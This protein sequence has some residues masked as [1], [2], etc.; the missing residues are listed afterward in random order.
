MSYGDWILCEYPLPDYKGEG[1]QFL[2]KDLDWADNSYTITVDGRLLNHNS[3][4]HS[5]AAED[6]HFHTQ[7]EP[8]GVEVEY[9]G[10][11]FFYDD[12]DQVYQARFRKGRV[13]WINASTYEELRRN[14]EK[15]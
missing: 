1:R 6:G 8:P 14:Y 3:G 2:T 11:I 9:D 5:P 7:Y 13:L 15:T 12:N 4:I 10:D